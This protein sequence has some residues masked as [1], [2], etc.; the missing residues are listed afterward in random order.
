MNINMIYTL[1]MSFLGNTIINKR[2]SNNTDDE[3]EYY[4][5]MF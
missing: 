3:K 2:F 5:N 1:N 4:E